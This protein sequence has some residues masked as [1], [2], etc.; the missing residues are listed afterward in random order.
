MEHQSEEQNVAQDAQC[1]N[2]SSGPA[3]RAIAKLR[4]ML[5]PA[6]AQ[7]VI[8]YACQDCGNLIRCALAAGCS[9]EASDAYGIPA[10]CLA[11]R[12]GKACSLKALLDGG[13]NVNAAGL[14][15]NTALMSAVMN[16]QKACARMLLPHSNLT[17]TDKKG[18]NALHISVC[19]G[20]WDCW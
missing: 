2:L 11:A 10:L 4:A 16:K 12:Y 14:L 5:P 8:A 3:K 19:T 1:G 15:G 7:R 13:A 20:N 17:A 6:Q 9:A 18:R